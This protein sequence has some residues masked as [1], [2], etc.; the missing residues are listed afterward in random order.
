MRKRRDNIRRA[1]HGMLMISVRLVRLWVISGPTS[2]ASD[3][4]AIVRIAEELEPKVRS[5]LSSGRYLAVL[6]T[7]AMCHK[8]TFW[9]PLTGTKKGPV[10]AL[11]LSCRVP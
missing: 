2:N 8:R 10:S 4:S 6:G 9:P 3:E 11:T 7:A 5:T 1:E